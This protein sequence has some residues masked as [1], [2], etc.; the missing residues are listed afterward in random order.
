M[1]AIA[2]FSISDPVPGFDFDLLINGEPN[3]G[4]TQR[5][6]EGHPHPD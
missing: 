5:Q 1:T 6:R 4:S 3:L 2:L